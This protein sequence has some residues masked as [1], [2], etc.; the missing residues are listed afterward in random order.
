MY[1][2]L[3]VPVDLAH[4][5]ALD[6]AL[7]TAADLAKMYTA[8][9]WYVGVTT[10]APGSV[11]HTPEEFAE[12]LQAFADAQASRHGVP[13]QSKALLSHDPSSDL[14]KTLLSAA[15]ALGA[16]LIVMA[17]HVPGVT[18]HIFHSHGGT[19]ASRSSVSVFVVR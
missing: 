3:M 10:T 8:A 19:I 12:R 14:S 16:D 5:D 6:K 4:A 11:A 9:L 1:K 2:T 15:D 13:A 7:G 17:S 18:D